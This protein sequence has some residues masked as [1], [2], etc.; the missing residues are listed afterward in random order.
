[1]KPR[2]EQGNTFIAISCIEKVYEYPPIRHVAITTDQ[3][4]AD[5]GLMGSVSDPVGTRG[6]SIP[7]RKE[8]KAE[9]F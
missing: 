8:E 5:K 2:N 4:S 9:K 6:N 7:R 3:M 1:M